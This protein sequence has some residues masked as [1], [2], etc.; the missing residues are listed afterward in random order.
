LWSL[1]FLFFPFC[2]FEVLRMRIRSPWRGFGCRADRA[3]ALCGIA[4]ENRSR[5]LQCVVLSTYF[6][7]RL[8]CGWLTAWQSLFGDYDALRRRKLMLDSLDGRKRG[9]TRVYVCTKLRRIEST[10]N[11]DGWAIFVK[12]HSEK[13]SLLRLILIK[14]ILYIQ[15]FSKSFYISFI[16]IKIFDVHANIAGIKLVMKL[17]RRIKSL[18]SW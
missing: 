10:G 8:L 15:L 4:Y 1:S 9:H 7:K 16:N 5:M 6:R 13:V 3:D 11:R 18:Q 14:S 17:E 12:F 2:P